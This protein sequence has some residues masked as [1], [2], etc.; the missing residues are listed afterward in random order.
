MFSQRLI[1]R[2]DQRSK[3]CWSKRDFS[4]KKK[5]VADWYRSLSSSSSSTTAISSSIIKDLW[6]LSDHHHNYYHHHH[7]QLMIHT[8]WWIKIF[9]PFNSPKKSQAARLLARYEEKK[10]HT[11]TDTQKKHFHYE[12]DHTHTQ[13]SLDYYLSRK[14]NF[15][16]PLLR[17]C[18]THWFSYKKFFHIWWFHLKIESIW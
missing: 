8:S 11:H 5:I 16:K 7:H 15:C 14:K 1:N 3:D 13:S 4:K 10:F 6:H 9:F 18:H 2:F 17:T 12:L